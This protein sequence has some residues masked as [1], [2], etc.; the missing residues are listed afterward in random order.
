[1]TFFT[2]YNDLN[3]VQGLAMINGTQLIT[4]IGAE[5]MRGDIDTYYTVCINEI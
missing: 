4:A 3:L 1:M 2:I 5:G